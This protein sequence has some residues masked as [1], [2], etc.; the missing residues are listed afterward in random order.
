[1]PGWRG[2]TGFKISVGRWRGR[3]GEFVEEKLTA[4]VEILHRPVKTVKFGLFTIQMERSALPLKLL[5]VIRE[6]NTYVIRVGCQP[7]VYGRFN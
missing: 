7:D 2:E 4:A 3:R 5:L 1:M 6:K